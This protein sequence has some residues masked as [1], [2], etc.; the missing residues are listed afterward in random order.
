MPL[1]PTKHGLLARAGDYEPLRAFS[2]GGYYWDKVPQKLVLESG[3]AEF[4]PPVETEEDDRGK[5]GRFHNVQGQRELLSRS[6]PIGRRGIPPRQLERLKE[7]IEDF[8]R[9]G[10]TER[11]QPQNREL[12]ERFQLPD[13]D[14]NPE[15]YRLTGPWWNR[16]LQ[17]LWGC[18]RARDSSL[19]A[20]IAAG[21]LKEDS[22]YNFRRLLG[23]LALLLLL[24]LL[25]A[26]W[27]LQSNPSDRASR[28]PDVTLAGSGSTGR[29]NTTALAAQAAAR[30]AQA[31]A[32]KARA[33]AKRAQEEAERSKAEAARKA[34]EAADAAVAARRAEEKARQAQQAAEQ[35]L[36]KAG[37]PQNNGTRATPRQTAPQPGTGA[38]PSGGSPGGQST[39]AASQTASPTTPPV[40]AGSGGPTPGSGAGG[41][42]PSNA[43]QP[44]AGGTQPGEAAAQPR[45]E[46]VLS[47]PSRLAPD[48]NMEISLEVRS[49]TGSQRALPVESWSYDDKTVKSEN[50][51]KTTL[52][53]GDHLIRAVVLDASG[54]PTTVEAVI[55]VV[56]GRMVRTGGKV[57][58]RPKTGP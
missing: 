45:Y 43:G 15:L 8:Q 2:Q 9:K 41:A 50:Q 57:S 44:S 27:W 36:A 40:G 25:P 6:K 12:I 1:E 46:I 30:K 33:D 54:K 14:R 52:G 58:L 20:T 39:P 38:A 18:E 31:E 28:K 16:R 47:A 55:T 17:I 48:G 35:A 32:A 37:T 34:K 22:L 11:A 5:Y 21:K 4:L 51:L 26:F 53:G 7:A 49:D 3:L 19:P 10:G 42:V 29:T 56:P 23:A 24:L 13:L